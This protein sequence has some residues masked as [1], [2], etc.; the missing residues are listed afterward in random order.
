LPSAEHTNRSS[1]PVGPAANTQKQTSIV[2]TCR[3]PQ[4]EATI[5]DKASFVWIKPI[6]KWYI[7]RAI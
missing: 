7:A 4:F 3:L 5:S 6:E 1:D 2:E